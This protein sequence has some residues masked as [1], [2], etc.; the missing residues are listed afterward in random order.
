MTARNART[1]SARATTTTGTKAPAP[2]GAA[3][4]PAPEPQA[5]AAPAPAPEPAPEPQAPAAPEPAPEP[6]PAPEP[7][8][9]PVAAPAPPVDQAWLAERL[10]ATLPAPLALPVAFASAGADM[11]ATLARAMTYATDRLASDIVTG[12]P[13]IQIVALTQRATIAAGAAGAM[14]ERL[15]TLRLAAEIAAE[16]L[17]TATGPFGAPLAEPD[18]AMAERLADG[19]PAGGS[20]GSAPKAPG[21]GSGSA[22]RATGDAGPGGFIVRAFADQAPGTFLRISD[23]R[24]LGAVAGSDYRPSPGAISQALQGKRDFGVTHIP[25]DRVNGG[26]QEEGARK[27]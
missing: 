24:R 6:A 16:R 18:R 19:L 26:T 9:P 12:G 15:A 14:A 10:A 2:A 7:P 17:A 11:S 8:A 25:S 1:T 27:R 13:V 23:I 3:P 5:P 4:A 22:P 20:R 21:S